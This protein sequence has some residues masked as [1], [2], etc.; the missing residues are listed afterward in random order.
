MVHG[1][2]GT[3]RTREMVVVNLRP[4]TDDHPQF[5][6]FDHA[7]VMRVLA[8]IT[9]DLDELARRDPQNAAEVGEDDRDPLK[10]H[11]RRLAE[12]EEKPRGHTA[13]EQREALRQAFGLPHYS[14]DYAD[15]FRHIRGQ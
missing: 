4:D 14:G 10:R 1:L 8:R 5:T 6:R 7:R 11:Q 12:P 9:S 15:Y 13:K 3:A 2:V